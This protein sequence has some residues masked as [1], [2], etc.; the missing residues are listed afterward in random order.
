MNS[1]TNKIF[2]IISIVLFVLLGVSGYFNYKYKKITNISFTSI[3]KNKGGAQVNPINISGPV[4]S[5]VDGKITIKTDQGEKDII[6]ND[7]TEYFKDYLAPLGPSAVTATLE[8]VKKDLVLG[9]QLTKNSKE[10][11]LIAE[12]VDILIP[13]VISGK[14]DTITSDGVIVDDGI[15]KFNISIVADTAYYKQ[16]QSTNNQQTETNNI[17]GMA[18][19]AK[20]SFSDVKQNDQVAVFLAGS[21]LDSEKKATNIVVIVQ[22]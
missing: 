9:V 16:A 11:N 14:I 2:I 3:I 8:D 20:I 12:K 22:N 13:N 5:V 15:T 17:N 4:L 18:G 21:V 7:S 1:R 6:V 19:P 10:N